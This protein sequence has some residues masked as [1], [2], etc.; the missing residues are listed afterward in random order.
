MTLDTFDSFQ[1]KT[2]SSPRQL[3]TKLPQIALGRVLQIPL[4]RRPVLVRVRALDPGQVRAVPVQA[5]E[6][7]DE[8]LVAQLVGGR[9]AVRHVLDCVVQQQGVARGLVDRAVEDVRYYFAL[10]RWRGKVS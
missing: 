5:H 2:P 9:A 6:A 1:S 10:F 7:R 8:E 3:P 4:Q